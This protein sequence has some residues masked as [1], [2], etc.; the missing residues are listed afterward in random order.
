MKREKG[1]RDIF[2]SDT[3]GFRFGFYYL[4]HFNSNMNS[5]TNLIKYSKSPSDGK[6]FPRV[7]DIWG[8]QMLVRNGMIDGNDT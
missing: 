7:T 2:I 3:K 5:Y 6:N 8:P 1:K 4:S